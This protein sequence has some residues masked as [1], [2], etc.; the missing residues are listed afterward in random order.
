MYYSDDVFHTFLD[1]DSVIYLAV[2]WT[3]TSLTVLIQNILN[4]VPKTNEALGVWNDMG[5]ILTLL[6][7]HKKRKHINL[8]KKSTNNKASFLSRIQTVSGERLCSDPNSDWTKRAMWKV[9]EVK[10]K[11]R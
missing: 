8:L 10:K 1:L 7:I 9:D 2:N 5:V 4:C 11:P 3:V 6:E